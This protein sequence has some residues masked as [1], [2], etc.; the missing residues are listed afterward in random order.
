MLS[1]NAANTTGMKTWLLRAA[2]LAY[3]PAT[4]PVP[5]AE[6]GQSS[7]DV[8]SRIDLNPTRKSRSQCPPLPAVIVD[9]IVYWAVD[10]FEDLIFLL[11]STKF[12][13]GPFVRK[14]KLSRNIFED[15]HYGLFR[16]GRA[17]VHHRLGPVFPPD[18]I[19]GIIEV[20]RACPTKTL[21]IQD[22][23]GLLPK[24][25]EIAFADCYY[26][27]YKAEIRTDIRDETVI[28]IATRYGPQLTALDLNGIESKSINKDTIITLARFCPNLIDLRV[29]EL[30]DLDGPSLRAIV[31]HCPRLEVFVTVLCSKN[32]CEDD[33]NYVNEKCK[34]LRIFKHMFGKPRR[35][36]C[37]PP[38]QFSETE[39]DTDG[40]EEEEEEEE[41]TEEESAG[42]PGDSEGDDEDG[43]DDECEGE[44]QI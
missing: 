14:L 23:T 19:D 12:D 21:N 42:W 25:Q 31:D 29:W 8:D 33:I 39:S 7:Q 28:T 16:N 10:R 43:D 9:M 24:L 20:L 17:S 37:G 1:I 40:E 13:Y 38:F 26:S 27:D 32:V 2:I 44:Q 34:R 35:M 15:V 5:S 22:N 18:G 36:V 11:T 4:A 6:E 30:W 3:P 41:F